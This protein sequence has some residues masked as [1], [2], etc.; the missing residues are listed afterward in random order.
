MQNSESI[1]K[2]IFGETLIKVV[3]DPQSI[4]NQITYLKMILYRFKNY[5]EKS[6]P[7]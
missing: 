5:R 6:D 3:N 2:A 7:R 1:G 4:N